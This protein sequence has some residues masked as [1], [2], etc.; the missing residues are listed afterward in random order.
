MLTESP[1]KTN[2]EMFIS[3]TIERNKEKQADL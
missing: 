2:I 3:I 1:R